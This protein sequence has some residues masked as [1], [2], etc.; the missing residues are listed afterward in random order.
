M[1]SN[2]GTEAEDKFEYHNGN[3]MCSLGQGFV[4]ISFLVNDLKEA[5]QRLKENKAVFKP[6]PKYMEHKEGENGFT[7]LL[8]PDDYT[9][10]ILQR[11]ESPVNPHPKEDAEEKNQ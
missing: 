9:V 10:E 3:D 11:G 1:D 6:L 2:W 7:F 4:S 8:D 5:V